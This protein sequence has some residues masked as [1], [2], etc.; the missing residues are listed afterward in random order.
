MSKQEAKRPLC[1]FYLMGKCRYTEEVCTFSH[2][3]EG[4]ETIEEARK[5]IP[6]PFHG[7]KEKPY[8]RCKHQSNCWFS[9][10]TDEEEEEE[11][12]LSEDLVCT[13][14]PS[15]SSKDIKNDEIKTDVD[16]EHEDDQQHEQD[17]SVTCALCLLKVVEKGHRFALF[18]DCDHTCCYR[19]ARKWH[20]NKHRR[21]A[22]L[23][24]PA[25]AK[26]HVRKPSHVPLMQHHC[27]YCRKLSKNLYPCK[28][29]LTG[30]KKK[31]YIAE[32]IDEQNKHQC[33]HYANGNCPF[34]D[35]C[36]FQHVDENGNDLFELQ[37]PRLK[38]KR[39]YLKRMDD[40][41]QGAYPFPSI[42]NPFA[43]AWW[44]EESDDDDASEHNASMPVS[45][46]VPES[47]LA[48]ENPF[49]F[50]ESMPGSSDGAAAEQSLANE[51]PFTYFNENE[52]GR[53]QHS[54]NNSA[55]NEHHEDNDMF[56]SVM[57]QYHEELAARDSSQEDDD[58]ERN[59]SLSFLRE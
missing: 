18:S 19:C 42:Q 3:S 44:D 27:P 56:A 1:R 32:Y 13:V 20:R 9:H 6:C 47:H 12:E 38:A 55:M 58:M 35:E 5:K 37:N 24:R 15:E 17:T 30:E 23:A 10:V 34:G 28:H 21:K 40:A 54:T 31:A 48:N 39:D 11:D 25:E 46:D 59:I 53:F 26:D 50:F 51:N 43:H 49:T 8:L 45:G 57:A 22:I 14:I 7:N 41:E 4:D 33:Q 36:N 2:R 16:E 29:Y 52:E